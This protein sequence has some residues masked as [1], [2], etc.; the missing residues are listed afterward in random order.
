MKNKPFVIRRI[1]YYIIGLISILLAVCAMIISVRYQYPESP[2]CKGRLGVGYP[3]LFICDNWG[4]G[5]PTNSWGE[6]TSVDV[7]N[8]GI[9]LGGFL[10]DLLFYTA[11]DYG[12]M[13]LLLTIYQ[14]IV[15]AQKRR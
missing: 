14:R 9:T 8:R 10:G 3:V 7:L 2:A 12:A 13:L 5:S 11:L 15:A 1:H 6:I 4:G